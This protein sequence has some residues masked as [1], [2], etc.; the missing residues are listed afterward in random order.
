LQAIFAGFLRFLR[1][2]S[3]V[4]FCALMHRNRSERLPPIWR[5][6]KNIFDREAGKPRFSFTELRAGA[7]SILIVLLPS[8]RRSPS[9]SHILLF[10]S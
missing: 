2:R 7:N 6:T 9:D 5:P 8:R 10:W 3:E 4:E 1:T